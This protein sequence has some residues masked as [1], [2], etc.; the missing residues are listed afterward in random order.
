MRKTRR[1]VPPPQKA[2]WADGVRFFYGVLMTGL[3]ITILVRSLLAGIITPPAIL[4]GLAFFAFGIYR[5]YVGIVRYRLFRGL[6][7]HSMKNS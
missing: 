5:V 1:L 2:T 3:G 7:D 6:R 4:I